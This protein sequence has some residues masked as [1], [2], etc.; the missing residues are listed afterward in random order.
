MY[1]EV[2]QCVFPSVNLHNV[3]NYNM[4]VVH[5][6]VDV[7]LSLLSIYKFLLHRSLIIG[8]LSYPR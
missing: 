1:V 2:L 4:C 3:R 5:G 7:L 6:I 8:G